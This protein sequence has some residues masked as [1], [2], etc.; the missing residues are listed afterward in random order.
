MHDQ[1]FI[2]SV[3]DHVTALE[4]EAKKR[5]NVWPRVH[6]VFTAVC[7]E[8]PDVPLY[9]PMA[10]MAN[11]VHCTAPPLRTFQAALVNLG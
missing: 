2:R 4:G 10:A 9:W 6:G 8:L 7:E 5:V 3:L 11:T 1:G